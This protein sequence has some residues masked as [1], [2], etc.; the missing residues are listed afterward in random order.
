M[1]HADHA[2]VME[3]ST[4]L[5]TRIARG[6]TLCIFAPTRVSDR[7]HVHEILLFLWWF[8]ICIAVNDEVVNVQNIS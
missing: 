4:Q 3:S 8:F 6:C 5:G 2:S 7:E 1:G